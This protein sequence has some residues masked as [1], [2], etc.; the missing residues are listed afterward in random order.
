MAFS[1]WR[2][3]LGS[4]NYASVYYKITTKSM[5]EK[6]ILE[7]SKSEGNDSCYWQ[8]RQ[9]TE[10]IDE[11]FIKGGKVKRVKKQASP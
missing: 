11:V 6:K 7:L 8:I 10:I 3:Y 5:A 9:T 2:K 4:D 1:V